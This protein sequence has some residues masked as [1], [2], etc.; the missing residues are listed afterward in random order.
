MDSCFFTI[1][2]PFVYIEGKDLFTL[3]IKN[4][5]PFFNT[6]QFKHGPAFTIIRIIPC[7]ALYAA[8]CSATCAAI[9]TLPYQ[10]VLS[11]YREMVV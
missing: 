5:Q 4:S 6:P 2:N 7:M 10:G 1:V 3:Q 11:S 8:V 9:A